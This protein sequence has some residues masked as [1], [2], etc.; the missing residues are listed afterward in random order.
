MRISGL[1]IAPTTPVWRPGASLSAGRDC[2]ERRSVLPNLL[3]LISGI[4]G[5]ALVDQVVVSAA[6]FLTTVMIGRFTDSGQLGA[7]AIGISVLASSFTI[8]GSLISLPYSIQLHR[9]QG[10]PA[11]NAGSSLAYSGLLSA[12]ATIIL[13]VTALG[14]FAGGAQSLLMA[15]TWA[16]AA[17]MPFALFREFFRRFAFTHLQMARVLLLDVAVASIQLSLLG[18]LGLTGRMSAVT[19]CGSIGISCGVA[20]VGWFYLARDDFAIRVGQIPATI[21]H[22]WGLGKWL[23]VN[24]IMVQVQRYATYWLSVVIAGAAVTGVYAACMSIV[25]FGNPLMFGLGNI[26]TRKLVLAWTEGGGAG[27][28]RQAIRD[29]LLLCAV[30]APF[31]LLIMFEGENMMHFLYHGNEYE[32]HGHTITV[33]AF[34]IF[35]SGAGGVGMPASNALAIME[36]PRAVVVVSAA[37]AV[38]T[39]V[40]VW[41]LMAVWGLLGA[42]YGLLLVNLFVSVGLWLEFLVT[43]PRASDSAPAVRVLQILTQT[44]NPSKWVISRLGE[45]D[46]SNVYAVRSADRQP[47]WGAYHD[48]VIKLYKPDAQ[49]TLDMVDAQF[50]SL[51]RLHGALDGRSVNGWKISTPKPLYVCKSP[52]ALVMTAVSGKKDLKSCAGADADLTPE[53]LKAVGRAVAGV[54]QESWSRGQLHGDLGLQNILYDIQRKN[55]S[56]IDPGTRES[57]FVCNDTYKRIHP[58]M[59]ELG[60]MLRDLGTDVR[61]MIGYPAARL[62]RQIF[63]ENALRAFIETIGSLE[64]K[65]RALQEIQAC[66]EA[67]LSKVLDLSWSLRGLWHW[68]LTQ[69]VVRRM[70]TVL[71]RLKI[72]LTYGQPL[73][74]QPHK[75]SVGT[76]RGEA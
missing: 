19:A 47:L 61:D 4:H 71:N 65:Q 7:Y 45:G 28:R 3:R 64:E 13:T 69:F 49:L 73:E 40:L 44:S 50:A 12:L 20:A 62:R 32:G 74:H 37:G 6:S 46:H 67:H 11:E 56:F 27:L 22:S 26:L 68:L 14:L 42:A 25:S 43:V 10:T 33:L 51:S 36:R 16:L 35:A 60:H 52:L 57:C 21:K 34:A 72:E 29:L 31:C 48:F 53:I 54:M 18:W 15:M 24:Q 30:L 1:P 70:G 23:L 38:L 41:W 59:L 66:A 55:L 39:V 5:F 8:Q 58:A 9:S 2:A 75:F 17:V 63:V 76:Q